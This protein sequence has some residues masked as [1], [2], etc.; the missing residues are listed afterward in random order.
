MFNIAKFFSGFAFW[1]GDKFGKL[2]FQIIII[3]VCLW[4]FYAK[5]IAK[6]APIITNA[7]QI[8]HITQTRGHLIELEIGIVKLGLL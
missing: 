3:A 8:Q 7:E 2:L 4:L 5:F 6:D 1:K